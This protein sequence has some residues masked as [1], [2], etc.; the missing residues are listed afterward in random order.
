MKIIHPLNSFFYSIFPE[1][2]DSNDQIISY[3]TKY[4]TYQNYVPKIE[5]KDDVV[6]ISIDIDAIAQQT[7][8]F[9]KVIAL[10][11]KGNFKDAKPILLKLL[12]SNPTVSEYHRILGQILSEEGKQDD[13]IDYLIDALRWDSKNSYALIMLGNIF[14]KFKNDIAT[15]KTYYDQA[16]IAN[17]NDHISINNIGANLLQQGKFSEA[18]EYFF[19]AVKINDEYPNTHFALS[20]I[21]IQKGDVDSAFYSVIKALKFNKNRDVLHQNSLKQAFDIAKAKLASNDGKKIFR[22][23]RS[24]LEKEG[25]VKID[26]VE[27]ANISTAAKME[28]AENY[29]RNS[30]I[31]RFNPQYPA[32]A[33]LIM[34][35]LVHLDLVLKAR[36]VKSNQLVV[37]NNKHKEL[38][39]KD[40]EQYLTKLYKRGLPEKTLSEYITSLFNGLNVQA[41]N[42]PIDLF[43]E[44]FLY[45]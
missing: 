17:P 21:A 34:H 43:I 9:K 42:A 41:F 27:D 32:I 11:E 7:T 24:D 39:V 16:L 33:H 18:E 19:K 8:D 45:T 13:A 35:E 40:Q 4:Y 37:S 14:A 28:F 44:D 22:Q 38:F 20:M 6:I 12:V 10:C 2:K 29:D 1:L 36:A 26:I 15:A 31:V 5:I 23:Y 3:L 30:H 25:K